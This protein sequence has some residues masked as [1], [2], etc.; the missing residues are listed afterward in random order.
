MD[1]DGGYLTCAMWGAIR[2]AEISFI[3]PRFVGVIPSVR[4]FFG[5]GAGAG[6]GRLACGRASRSRLAAVDI[7][8]ADSLFTPQAA[9]AGS[10][11]EVVHPW[12]SVDR[13]HGEGDFVSLI[14][15]RYE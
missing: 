2:T 5:R 14:L 4:C 8:R 3:I 13:A 9:T 15:Q 6:Q 7:L 12:L 11:A 1:G 10:A